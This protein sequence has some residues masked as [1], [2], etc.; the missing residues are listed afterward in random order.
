MP[1]DIYEVLGVPRNAT[2]DE[3]KGAYRKLA[4]K[5]HPDRNPGDKQSEEKFKEINQAYEV[6]ADSQKRQLYDQYG[7]AGLGAA[8]GA[9]GPGGAEAFRGFQGGFG[10]FGF[11]DVF[12]DVLEGFFGQGRGRAGMRARKG[13]S[14]RHDLT[15]TL[16]QAYHGIEMPLKIAK[17]EICAD[18]RGTRAKP[19]TSPKT[20]PQCRG[21]GKVQMVQ[22][23][24]SLSQACPRCH[25][26]GQ[27]IVSPCPACR[28]AGRT[29]RAAEMR[30]RIPAGIPSGTTL[31]IGGAGDIGERGGTPGDLYIHV[32]VKED[33]RFE[34]NDD[35]LIH[36]VRLS[37]PK[38][39]LGCEIDIP[40][41]NAQKCTVKVPPG[42]QNGTLLRIKERG[43]PRFQGRG[44]GDLFARVTLEI[45]KYVTGG[46]KELLEKL[47]KS[48]L[49]GEGEGFFKKVFKRT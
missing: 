23:F 10:D 45:P 13:A 46:Q 24:F 7:F 1:R 41:L 40:T 22:G 2:D 34:R 39:V 37:Y 12:E 49:E 5:Y 28:G 38:V 20:C 16:E 47:E 27:I 11:G 32:V 31:R 43:M 44:Y 15:I 19:G 4:L 18:C 30:V 48:F 35:D 29:E 36:E 26:E 14:L 25:G 6:L 33:P 3:I 9:G 21:S 42:T 17:R 8:S